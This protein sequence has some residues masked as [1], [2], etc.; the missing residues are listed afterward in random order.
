MSSN[1]VNE[2]IDIE[3]VE[4]FSA[5]AGNRVQFI[6]VVGRNTANKAVFQKTGEQFDT[7]H[8]I[9]PRIAGSAHFQNGA[10]RK[11]RFHFIEH[12]KKY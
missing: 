1:E 8:I 4:A 5:V 12:E 2:N 10:L 9:Q 3:I 6:V 7:V 11:R